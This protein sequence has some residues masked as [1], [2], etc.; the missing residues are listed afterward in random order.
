MRSRPSW[1]WPTSRSSLPSP[2]KSPTN[3]AAW[4]D[5]WTSMG[6]PAAWIF[7]GVRNPAGACAAAAAGSRIR[8]M[9]QQ[10]RRDTVIPPL[11]RFRR[12][13][14][15][16]RT[17]NS[18]FFTARQ[19]PD[20]HRGIP[21]ARVEP[22]IVG[23]ERHRRYGLGQVLQDVDLAAAGALPDAHAL[24]ARVVGADNGVVPAVGRK[25]GA[26]PVLFRQRRA[27]DPLAGRQLPD[28][29]EPLRLALLARAGLGRLARRGEQPPP[30]GGEGEPAPVQEI[31]GIEMAQL[32]AAGGVEYVDPL[33]LDEHEPLAVARELG[34]DKLEQEQLR[35]SWVVAAF[36]DLLLIHAG[37]DEPLIDERLAVGGPVAAEEVIVAEREN[38]VDAAGKA[39]RACATVPAVAGQT[40]AILPGCDL[41]QIDGIGARD[42]E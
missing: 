1:Y 31:P 13:P 7:T 8:A 28:G 23:R 6:L 11:R 14:A 41:P 19:F 37:R 15:V 40:V 30:V 34:A 22:A 20:H 12:S 35:A 2:S 33:M 38:L 42:Q 25:R 9:V 26:R 29:R 3:G 21:Q 36:D 32:G 17:V 24:A 18:S 16:R 27:A 4:P 5:R 39:N 10:V